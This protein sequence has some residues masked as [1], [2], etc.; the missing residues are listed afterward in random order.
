VRKDKQLS[1]E[2]H[3]TGRVRLERGR[4]PTKS[5][6]QAN[7][8]ARSGRRCGRRGRVLR[9]TD[10]LIGGCFS[11]LVCR[12]LAWVEVATLVSFRLS[13]HH[14][15]WLLKHLSSNVEGS[16]IGAA[17][18]KPVWAAG[19]HWTASARGSRLPFGK[20]R[21]NTGTSGSVSAVKAQAPP[22]VKRCMRLRTG[23]HDAPEESSP[24]TRHSEN[25]ANG[26]SSFTAHRTRARVNAPQ[27]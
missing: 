27:N 5:V 17:I 12:S 8:V 6:V 3:A 16:G 10:L 18:C 26:R 24:R 13:S 19:Q 2:K 23:S 15:R 22:T 11:L 25:I 9:R 14:L 21:G 4:A 20:A 7:F 1:D